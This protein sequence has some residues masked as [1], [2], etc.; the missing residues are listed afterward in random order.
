MLISPCHKH[1]G[2]VFEWLQSRW[3]KLEDQLGNVESP[4]LREKQKQ[5]FQHVTVTKLKVVMIAIYMY[6]I[7]EFTD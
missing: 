7:I 5:N 3:R 4:Q 2:F 1:L 6:A